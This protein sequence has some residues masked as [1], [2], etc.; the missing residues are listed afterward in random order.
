ME[1]GSGVVMNGKSQNRDGCEER[2]GMLYSACSASAYL[3]PLSQH[4]FHSHSISFLWNSFHSRFEMPIVRET[5]VP[6]NYLDFSR[7]ALVGVGF[8]VRVLIWLDIFE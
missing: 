2:D 3:Y 5:V 7:N 4:E 8:A 1:A 6:Q